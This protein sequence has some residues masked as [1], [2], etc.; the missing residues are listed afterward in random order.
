MVALPSSRLE[1]AVLCLRP[2]IFGALAALLA[3]LSAAVPALAGE[4]QR[5]VQIIE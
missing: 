1:T 5:H 4:R 3:T 2:R